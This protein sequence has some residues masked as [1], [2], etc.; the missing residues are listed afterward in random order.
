M[1]LCALA[2]SALLVSGCALF[3]SEDGTEP[4]DLVDF[5]STAEVDILWR[6]KVGSGRAGGVV[7][8]KPALDGEYI[9]AADAKGRVVALDSGSG[10][11]VWRKKTGDEITG[12]VS[13]SN[14][15]VLY[16]TGGGEVVALSSENG[17]ELW[18]KALRGEVISVPVTDGQLVAAQ[19]MDGRLHA[20]NAETG[21]RRWQYESPPPVLTL[22]GTASPTITSSAVIA[23]FATGKVMAFNRDNGLMLWERRVALPQGR[24]EIERMV[25]IDAS[26]L[27][28]D[29]VV[30]AASFQGKAM[31]INRSNGRAL[32]EQEVSTHQ[33]LA[34]AG[35]TLF[36]SEADSHVK[37]FSGSNGSLRWENEQL[38]RREINGPQV[39]G[40][41]VAVGDY[42]GYLHVMN[43][44]DGEFVARRRLDRK[45]LSNSM[46]SDGDVL[47]V[48]GDSGRL[49]ALE[50][51]AEEE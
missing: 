16:G 48:L 43:Q 31:A 51:V 40:D 19:T 22:R 32:W 18:R 15:I 3:S 21:E 35:R 27:L 38:L 5:E 29:D 10:K 47:Y 39:V 45:G 37:A 44:S 49:I 12:G 46:I 26:P 4:L 14:G 11:R 23:G 17:D 13:S 20:L 34:A 50:V 42:D 7:K 33:D 24:S 28:V 1:R 8:L 2:L 6:T 25:D 36:L 30:Y 41:Y 9:Y